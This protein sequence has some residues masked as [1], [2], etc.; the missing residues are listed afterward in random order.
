MKGFCPLQ[1]LFTPTSGTGDDGI[2]AC[3]CR[4]GHPHPSRSCASHSKDCLVSHNAVVLLSLTEF[5]SGPKRDRYESFFLFSVGY[6]PE[7]FHTKDP[8]V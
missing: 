2:A 1:P 4:R 7:A 5:F 8:L 6:H 3:S